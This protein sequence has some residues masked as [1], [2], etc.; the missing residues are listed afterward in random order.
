M[1]ITGKIPECSRG[2]KVNHFSELLAGDCGAG[3]ANIRHLADEQNLIIIH[4]QGVT[5]HIIRKAG[6]IASAVQMGAV[7]DKVVDILLFNVLN[8]LESTGV[9]AVLRRLT[10]GTSLPCR[11]LM[12]ANIAQLTPIRI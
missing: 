6:K 7:N 10:S 12:A 4:V 2:F 3:L 11:P 5:H 8:R 1:K 9:A